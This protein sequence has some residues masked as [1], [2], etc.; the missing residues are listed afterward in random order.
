MREILQTL[1]LAVTSIPSVACVVAA[2][3]PKP[4][5]ALEVFSTL[6]SWFQFTES[7]NTD[8]ATPV[9]AEFFRVLAT[10]NVFQLI[11][12]S[13]YGSPP[14][15]PRN[16]LQL[17][18]EFPEKHDGGTFQAN[19]NLKNHGW[20][21][22]TPKNKKTWLQNNTTISATISAS[23]TGFSPALLPRMRWIYWIGSMTRG[24]SATPFNCGFFS[25]RLSDC[26]EKNDAKQCANDYG[27]T[28]MV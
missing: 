11:D 25:S 20:F 13:S 18:L 22:E 23:S 6:P 14:L 28:M 1:S 10:S 5:A 4:M 19:E 16:H 3:C 9:C 24:S 27:L 17:D 12:L 26:H 8:Y 21:H 7:Q 15:P 2:N